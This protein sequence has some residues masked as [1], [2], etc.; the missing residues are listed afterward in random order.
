MAFARSAAA[1]ALRRNVYT[2][3]RQ[4]ASFRTITQ[5]ALRP[6]RSH[7]V[8]TALVPTPNRWL[9]TNASSP[10]VYEF[11]DI[12]KLAEAPNAETVLIGMRFRIAI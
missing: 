11:G 9:S 7:L 5:P 8:Q 12:K 10:K 6:G 3:Y 1:V 4:I 2:Q